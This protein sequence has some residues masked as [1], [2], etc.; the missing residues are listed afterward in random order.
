MATFEAQVEGL[1]S[2]DIGS[3]GTAPTQA[4]LTQFL[5]D[6]ASEV[7]NSMPMRLRYLCATEDTFNS[8]AVGSEAKVLKSGHILSVLRTDGSVY[9][10]CR[11]IPANIA[12]RAAD[13]TFATAHMETATQTDPVYYIYN[14]KINSLPAT[15]AGG[16]TAANKYLEINR[17]AVAYSHDSMDDSVASFPLEYEYLVVLY[18]ALKSLQNAMGNKT[19][20][21]PIAPA[22]PGLSVQSVTITGTAPVYTAPSVALAFG[23]L[24]GYIDS[25]EDTELAQ[26]KLQE[27]NAK[28]N[29]FTSNMQNALNEFN[30][31]NVEY[32]A[33]L[34]KD[35]QDAQYSDS[36][37]ARKLQK[38]SSE[39]QVYQAEIQKHTTDYQWMVG[40]YQNLMADYQR[41]LQSLSGR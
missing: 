21:L 16:G 5:I 26:A 31:A 25:S 30:D 9:Y 2:I 24:S 33:T 15:L 28:L 27:I 13:T 3:S 6:G 10:P 11:E 32:Q 39:L 20:S 34:Q 7:I 12:G 36:H 22:V 23:Q 4:E 18:A 35:I 40:Q 38:Y 19:S 1:T 17:P 37:E 14:G 29:E 41:G 8:A